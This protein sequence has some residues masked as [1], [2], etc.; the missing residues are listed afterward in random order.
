ML[1]IIF[2]NI[3]A[4][5]ST[6]AKALSKK[7]GFSLIQFD[8]LV[9]SVTGKENMYDKNNNFLL[10]NKDIENVHSKMRENAKQI[11]ETDN[12]VVVE[13]MYFKPQREK[14]I[15]M[16][17]KINIKYKII[18]VICDEKETQKRIKKRITKNNQSAGIR[19]FIENKNSLGKEKIKHLVLDTTNKNIKTC[20]NS[21]IKF[22]N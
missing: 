2:G 11:L 20:V 15:K 19:L 8:P 4:G 21:V 5:K 12:G 16:A 3:G 13:S 10:S 9:P 22:I 6:I 14:I 18:E 7:L 1:I 17:E